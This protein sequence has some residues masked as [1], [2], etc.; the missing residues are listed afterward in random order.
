MEYRNLVHNKT[1]EL[2]ICYI[3]YRIIRLSYWNKY[4][5]S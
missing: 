3:D 1:Q 4:N 5:M 2:H